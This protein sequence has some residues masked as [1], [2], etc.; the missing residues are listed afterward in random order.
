MRRLA[1][2]RGDGISPAFAFHRD[3]LVTGL[4]RG[5]LCFWDMANQ[6]RDPLVKLIMKSY[7]LSI[8]DNI[9]KMK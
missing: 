1:A 7:L 9:I 4:N 8:I 3:T 2:A 6:A 5:Q